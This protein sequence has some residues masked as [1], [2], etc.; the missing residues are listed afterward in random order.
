MEADNEGTYNGHRILDNDEV[1]IPDYQIEC[2]YGID[3]PGMSVINIIYGKGR[4]N[5]RE[6]PQQ[7]KER[8]GFPSDTIYIIVLLGIILT[9]VVPP[10]SRKRV[11][12]DKRGGMSSSLPIFPI[13]SLFEILIRIRYNPHL[14]SQHA[15][16][17]PLSLAV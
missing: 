10:L 17:V 15:V 8:P 11:A 14:I 2:H 5:D 1:E 3:L 13:V 6:K 7:N 16:L 4:I 12:T 9:A